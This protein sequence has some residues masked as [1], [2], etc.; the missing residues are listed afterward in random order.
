MGNWDKE[1]SDSFSANLKTVEGAEGALDEQA[2]IYAEC[3]E[4]A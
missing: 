4:A 2:D 3:W 1:D